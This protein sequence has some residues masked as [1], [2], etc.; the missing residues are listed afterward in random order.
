VTRLKRLLASITFKLALLYTVMFAVS[1]SGLFYFVFWTTSGFAQ[2]QLEAAIQAEVNGFQESYERAGTGGLVMAMNRRVDPTGRD[3]GIFLLVDPVGTPV[4]G[5]LRNWPPRVAIDGI[6]VNFNIRNP[7]QDPGVLAEARALQFFTPEGFKLLVG[8]DIRESQLFRRQLLQSLNIGLGLTVL[9][10]LIGGFVFGSSAM[11]RIE[12]ITNTCRSIMSGDLSQRVNVKRVNDEV[13][14]LSQSINAMLDQIER[15]MRGMQ[16]VSDN[17]A[18]DLRTPLTRLRSR[19]EASL[20]D[21]KDPQQRD[22]IESAIEDA[23]NLLATFSALLRIARAEA[24]LQRNFIA[25]DLA[26]I[27]EDVAEMYGPLAEEKGLSF[28]ARFEP[29]VFA[30][31]DRNLVAQALANLIDNAIKYTPEGGAVTV[32]SLN[33]KGKPSYVVADTGPGIP[34]AYKEK[35]LERLFRLEESRTSP[36]SGL[37]LSLVHAVARSHSLDLKLDDNHPGLRVTMSFPEAAPAPEKAEKPAL[38]YTPSEPLD[39]DSEK[40]A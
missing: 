39:G 11:R 22:V 20:R 26:A 18:H 16:Q 7:D 3:G 14:R 40:A 4:A 12:A 23:D 21:I 36:G 8:R 30:K 32:T 5:N 10:G 13:G 15:L 24:G 28:T 25:L 9:L 17:I 31:G 35:V 19:L 34:N 38:D 6:W 2:R 29:G 33:L 27:G 37:G 1:V